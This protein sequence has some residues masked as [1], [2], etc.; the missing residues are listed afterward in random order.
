MSTQ[1]TYLATKHRVL[2]RGS[3]PDAF[4]DELVAW[5]R[6]ADHA[7]FLPNAVPLD[8]YGVIRETLGPWYLTEGEPEP[9]LFHRR[10]AMCEAMRCH[11]GLEASWKWNEG[12][13]RTNKTSL[14]HKEGE[15]TGV[16]QVSYD[17]TRLGGGKMLDYLR[18]WLPSAV[19][20]PQ[21]FIDEMKR[22][23]CLSLD[24]YA[25]LVRVNTRWAG[26]LLR[27]EILP[28]LRQDAVREFERLLA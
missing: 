20:N 22:K 9:Y 17:S 11:A 5:A 27:G 24:Y 13:D 1:A 18:L 7:V 3:P 26:P 2:D 21:V 15:E 25:H 6:T 4:L 16:F 10:A 14:T 19:V 23:P 28:E 8:I 12:V